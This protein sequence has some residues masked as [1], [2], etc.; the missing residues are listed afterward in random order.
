MKSIV[1]TLFIFAVTICSAQK[2]YKF[3]YLVTYERTYFLQDSITKQIIYLTNS[4]DNSYY[5]E[6][7]NKDS[8]DYRMIFRQQDKVYADV[9]VPKSQLVTAESIQLECESVFPA[10]NVYKNATKRY[11]YVLLPDTLIDQKKYAAYKLK[12]QLNLKKRIRRGIGTNLYI[13]DKSTGFHLPILSHPTAYEEWKLNKNIPNGLFMEK[14][15]ITPLGEEFSSEKLISYKKIDKK[16]I[17]PKTCKNL[18]QTYL[19][20]STD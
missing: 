14:K 3:D 15:F 18:I 8:L 20:E 16:I 2:Q 5:A 12:C 17:I 7:T 19:S 13:I 1:V 11:E 9:L 10:K 4:K 6:L